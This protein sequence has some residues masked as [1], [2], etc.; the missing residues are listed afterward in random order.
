MELIETVKLNPVNKTAALVTGKGERFVS[1]KM[2]ANLHCDS[3]IE[4]IPVRPGIKSYVGKNFG[5]FTVVGLHGFKAGGKKTWVVRCSCGNYETRTT[6]AIINTRN[7]K[8]R[9]Q[10]CLE[11]AFLKRKEEYRRTGQNTISDRDQ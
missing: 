2:I 7:T 4:T 6:R 3:P 11:V 1:S 5:T 8:D 10:K 9:C